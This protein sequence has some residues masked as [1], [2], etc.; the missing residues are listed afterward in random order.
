MRD[1]FQEIHSF[2]QSWPLKSLDAHMQQGLNSTLQEARTQLQHVLNTADGCNEREPYAT[3]QEKEEDHA[4]GTSHSAHSLQCVKNFLQEHIWQELSCAKL[5]PPLAAV[6]YDASVHMG[7]R[8]ALRLVQEA[9][10]VVGDA[11]LDEFTPVAEKGIFHDNLIQ[12]TKN[13]HE[14]GLAFYTARLCVRQRQRWYLHFSQK[15]STEKDL[16]H[17]KA[18]CQALL[19]F[20]ALLERDYH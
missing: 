4:E 20:L 11:H 5:P 8:E 13:L 7:K 15:N 16:P 10:N 19:E 12:L 18:R 3:W 14:H 2:T 6:L 17:Y 9:C 1:I